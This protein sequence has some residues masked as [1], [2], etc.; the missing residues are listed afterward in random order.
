MNFNEKLSTFNHEQQSTE[1][2]S[3]LDN[4]V[5]SDKEVELWRYNKLFRQKPIQKKNFVEF[6]TTYKIYINSLG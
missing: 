4:W 6:N 3:G 5:W 2:A 1:L